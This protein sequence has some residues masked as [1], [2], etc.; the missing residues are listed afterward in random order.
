MTDKEKKEADNKRDYDKEKYKNDEG[1][2]REVD[3]RVSEKFRNLFIKEVD[4][5]FTKKENALDPKP[6][7]DN[8]PN[9]RSGSEQYQAAVEVW[10][11]NNKKYVAV[12]LKMLIFYITVLGIKM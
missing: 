6:K 4:K 9:T 3:K 8:Y 5:K 2:K 12:L 11:T 1:Y 7:R 10:N